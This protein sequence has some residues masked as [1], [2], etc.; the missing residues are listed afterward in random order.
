MH[1]ASGGTS[2]NSARSGTTYL[3]PDNVEEEGLFEAARVSPTNLGLLLNARQAAC[4]LGF[5]TVPEF[6]KLTQSQPRNIC[7]AWRSS[8]ATS[9]TGTTRRR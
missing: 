1:C 4:E 9:T 7:A 8:A 2:T 5:L 6:V 3:I